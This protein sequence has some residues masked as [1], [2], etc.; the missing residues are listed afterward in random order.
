MIARLEGARHR[1][2]DVIETFQQM[3]C[4]YDHLTV[5]YE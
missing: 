4:N 3:Y 5:H 1:E 2:D